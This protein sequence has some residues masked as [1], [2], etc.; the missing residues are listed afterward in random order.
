MFE[1]EKCNIKKKAVI[2][3]KV[4]LFYCR[5]FKGYWGKRCEKINPNEK[6]NTIF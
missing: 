4:I 5:C 1:F 2:T 6:R 3:F